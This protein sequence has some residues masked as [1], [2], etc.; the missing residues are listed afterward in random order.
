[1]KIIVFIIMVILPTSNGIGQVLTT[2]NN[3]NNIEMKHLNI[4]KIKEMIKLLN[5][6]NSQQ[7]LTKMFASDPNVEV[8]AYIDNS[9]KFLH[10]SEKDEN[11]IVSVTGNEIQGF[12]TTEKEYSSLIEENSEF[13]GDGSLKRLTYFEYD[14]NSINKKRPFGVWYYYDQNGS[15][16]EKTEYD[17]EV[18]KFSRDDVREF[19]VKNYLVED[20]IEYVMNNLIK[21]ARVRVN[22]Q[23]IQEAQWIVSIPESGT[24]RRDRVLH[25]DAATGKIIREHIMEFSK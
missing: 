15:L 12:L 22:G 24:P 20:H 10:Y 6:D 11:K 7:Y 4:E 23:V 25:V 14:K 8:T 17:Y 5:E 13:Y 16:I 21:S 9:S 2:Y 19:V 3:K 1:M 18:F